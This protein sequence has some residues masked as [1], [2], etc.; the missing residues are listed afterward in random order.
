MTLLVHSLI[1]SGA[2]RW[3]HHIALRHNQEDWSYER[4]AHA[5][6]AFAAHLRD[7]ELPRN[8]RVAIYADKRPEVVAAMMGAG[9]ASGVFVPVNPLLKAAQVEYILR[10][11][12]VHTLVTTSERLVQLAPHLAQCRDLREVVVL[13]GMAA[14]ASLVGTACHPW[15]QV[16]ALPEESPPTLPIIDA[17]MVAIL[18]TSGSTGQPKGVVL[19]HRNVVAGAQSVAQY[20]A[21]DARDRLLAVLPLSFDYG[22]NQLTSAFYVGATVVLL[23]HLFPRDVI[24]AVQRERITGLAGVPPLWMQLAE[25]SWPNGIDAHLR[26]ITNSGGH[27]P[28]PTLRSLRALLPRTQPFLMYGLTEA[29]RSTFLS[30]EE[31]DRRPDS[32][33]RA[34]PNAEIMVV[35]PDGSLCDDD[36]PGELVHRGVHVALGYWNDFERTRVRFR[37]APG[38]PTGLTMP[39]MAVWS[40][41]TVRRDAAGYLYF[42]G[43]GDEMI[44]T[45]GYRISPNEIETSLLGLP[46]VHE[47]VV[48][49]VPDARQGQ[50][51]VA[52]LCASPDLTEAA[53][54]ATCRQQL[55]TY[56]VPRQV[57]LR[58]E[59]LPRNANG[60]IDRALLVRLHQQK[61]NNTS[62][63]VS[64]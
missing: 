44:K 28:Q 36:E 20:L 46:G 27:M 32:I 57:E 2:Q 1:L 15:P 59:E 18:Y 13:P 56:M 50:T 37:P 29:F 35:R 60:K 9:I 42:V 23:N 43:R 64:A 41:D 61:C 33:G 26:Y 21:L 34:I 12:E 47:A 11:S 19:S 22:L 30:P 54:L 39:E 8:G 58:S 40:G 49:G 6:V 5:S 31:L 14:P 48:F 16:A 10:D 17:D 4:L 62:A 55:P 51:V 45:S 24:N 63:G 25:Q 38:Q 7:Q 52:V 53:V 3:P